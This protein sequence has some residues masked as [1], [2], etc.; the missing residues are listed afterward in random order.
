VRQRL[1]VLGTRIDETVLVAR[2]KRVLTQTEVLLEHEAIPVE[3][4]AGTPPAAMAL[5][6]GR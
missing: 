2:G 5:S 1:E 6:A 3:R 4:L